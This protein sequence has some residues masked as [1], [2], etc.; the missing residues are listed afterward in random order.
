[1]QKAKASSILL[2]SYFAVKNMY[3]LTILDHNTR[4][5]RYLSAYL[6]LG[7][8]PSSGCIR[9]PRLVY[10]LSIES[11][12]LRNLQIILKQHHGV[13]LPYYDECFKIHPM[14]YWFVKGRTTTLPLTQCTWLSWYRTMQLWFAIQ[15]L[16]M[17]TEENTLVSCPTPV[18]ENTPVQSRQGTSDIVSYI[19]LHCVNGTGSILISQVN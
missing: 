12:L 11:H 10:F 17:R 13:F 3:N 5:G 7:F 4:I 14:S 16:L 6:S 2:T 18:R 9:H 1:M 15:H 19:S 8:L